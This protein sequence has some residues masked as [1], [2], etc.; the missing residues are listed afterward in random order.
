VVDVF[1]LRGAGAERQELKVKVDASE[2][3]GDTGA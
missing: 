1:L 2:Q 3:A